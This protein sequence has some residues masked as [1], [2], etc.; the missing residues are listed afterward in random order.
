MTDQ[1]ATPQELF[2]RLNDEFR[3]T[4]DAC[5]TAENAKCD[6][7]FSADADGLVQPWLGRVWCNPPY[8]RGL[9]RWVA[10]AAESAE[11]GAIV[12][13]LL[14]ARVD[15]T[16]W[17]DYV[18]TKAEVRFLRGRLRFGD[19]KNSAPFPSAIAVWRPSA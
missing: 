11:A 8:G 12:V 2:D 3:F 4:L 6:A 10:K 18:A 13:A 16:W 15:T 17:H 14:P 19:A 5:A 9:G 7:F 1:W